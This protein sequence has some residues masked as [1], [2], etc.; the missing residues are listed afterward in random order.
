MLL[1]HADRRSQ[2]DLDFPLPLAR[3]DALVLIA[4]V[5]QVLGSPKHPLLQAMGLVVIVFQ[6]GSRIIMAGSEPSRKDCRH[7]QVAQIEMLALGSSSLLVS[8][9]LST[10][11]T[12]PAAN[13]PLGMHYVVTRD[14]DCFPTPS[15]EPMSDATDLFSED[16][17]HTPSPLQ[18]NVVDL[19]ESLA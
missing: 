11:A 18:C 19:P 6:S 2:L 15:T 14:G 13:V 9:H 5:Y 10:F 3:L 1:A 17:V 4:L 7:V 16:P 8:S 12:L